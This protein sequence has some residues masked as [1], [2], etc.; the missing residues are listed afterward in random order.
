MH[1]E[2]RLR[3]SVNAIALHTFVFVPP[4]YIGRSFFSP[5]SIAL[6]FLLV[7]VAVQATCVCLFLLL[8]F[9]L[10]KVI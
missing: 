4:T 9:I 7:C 5:F 3:G 10:N 6:I 2:L 8:N 1:V